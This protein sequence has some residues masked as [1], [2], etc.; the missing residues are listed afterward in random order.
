M[1]SDL[2]ITWDDSSFVDSHIVEPMSMSICPYRNW[3]TKQIHKITTKCMIWWRIIITR[4]AR[5]AIN[6]RR[7]MPT[8]KHNLYKNE[9]YVK[10][11]TFSLFIS[12]FL[13]SSLSQAT[14]SWNHFTYSFYLF[15]FLFKKRV[16]GA[17]KVSPLVSDILIT[18]KSDKCISTSNWCCSGM[19]DHNVVPRTR[20]PSIKRPL[21]NI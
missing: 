12:A 1:I 14:S 3:R 10:T 21:K 13:I 19:W 11:T 2:A 5:S 16:P 17:R 8:Y 9:N 18:L 6:N 20:I 7:M 15:I 4:I